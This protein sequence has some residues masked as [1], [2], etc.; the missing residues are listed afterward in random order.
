MPPARSHATISYGPIFVPMA[1]VM[2]PRVIPAENLR[3]PW[4]SPETLAVSPNHTPPMKYIFLVVSVATL[5]S[6]CTGGGPVSSPIAPS[7][8]T[9]SAPP[10]PPPTYT[11]SG[12]VSEVTPSGRVPVEGATV[13]ELACD[14]GYNV[15]SHV[16][17]TATTDLNG[18][19]R[20]SELST[21]QTHF[22]WVFKTG[23]RADEL[24]HCEGCFGSVTITADT[25]LDIDVVRQ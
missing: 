16:S 18:F 7:P 23:Y 13:E 20:L 1:V 12:V 17:H 6:A 24:P 15:C 22:L 10:V 11:L 9:S 2:E 4:V 19:Y 3:S 25:K 5:M 21:N 8:S 14:A